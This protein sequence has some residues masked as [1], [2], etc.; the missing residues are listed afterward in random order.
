MRLVDW[1][2]DSLIFKYVLHADKSTSKKAFL[3]QACAIAG[4]ILEE[5]FFPMWEQEY[6]SW[7]FMNTCIDG[8]LPLKA[9][10]QWTES[11]FS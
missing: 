7:G 10:A 11:N 6:L 4:T 5:A 2:T 3:A 1:L 9:T 8:I